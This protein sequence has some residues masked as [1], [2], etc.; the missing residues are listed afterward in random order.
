M[1][2]TKL[3]ITIK[4]R[5]SGVTWLKYVKFLQAARTNINLQLLCKDEH[6]CRGN[7]LKPETHRPRYDLHI[8]T[9][10]VMYCLISHFLHLLF[11]MCNDAIN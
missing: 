9:G 4:Y 1:W 5:R 8:D 7:D 3:V 2:A 6:T 10:N 11:L